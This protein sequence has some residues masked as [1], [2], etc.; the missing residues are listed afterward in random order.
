MWVALGFKDIYKEDGVGFEVGFG[1]E[2][3]DLLELPPLYT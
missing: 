1:D 3:R 2:G